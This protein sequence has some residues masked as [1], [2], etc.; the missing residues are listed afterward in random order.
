M[1]DSMIAG[2][3]YCAAADP[4]STK[5]PAPMIAPIPRVIRF[6]GP[7]ARFKL[8]A[9]VSA[10]SFI[11]MSRGLHF[12]RLAIQR[13]LFLVL[14]LAYFLAGCVWTIGNTREYQLEQ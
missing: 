6:T 7:S 8:C 1:K 9:P 4:V 13:C 12:S 10:A 3:A 2:P 5:I 11:S 14:R